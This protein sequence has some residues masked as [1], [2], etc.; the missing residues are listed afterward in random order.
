MSTIIRN[1]LI[2][3][4]IAS[5]AANL[6]MY[7][8]FRNRRVYMSI[9]GHN[10][11][12]QDIYDYLV[13]DKGEA[14]KAILI[15]RI[16]IDDA[17]KEKNLVPSENEV[18]DRFNQEKEQNWQFAR[19]MAV[20]AWLEP[21][22]RARIRQSMELQRLMVA[23]IPVTD[24][25]IAE[26]YKARP[27]MYDTPAKA[28]CHMALLKPTANIDNVKQLMEKN[29]TPLTIQAN[30]GHELLFLGENKIDDKDHCFIFF[31]PFNT[32]QNATIFGLKPDQIIDIPPGQFQQEGFKRLIIKML[33][34]V[35][36][37]KADLN[38]KKTREKIRMNIAI[39]RAPDQ[40]KFLLSLWDK[41]KDSFRSEDRNDKDYIEQ[42]LAPDRKD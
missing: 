30:F 22:Y 3:A 16:L 15:E 7:Q 12:Q 2:V 4:L 31:Q 35:P 29:I 13:Q 28:Y 19:Q 26:E 42:L 9:N 41:A 6:F 18:I 5:L 39:K 25:Q 36:G 34:I 38:D 20:N 37:K 10:I 33:K 17:A 21:E 11:T 23:D 24:D 8:R 27:A 32:P 14:V 40:Q 1:L